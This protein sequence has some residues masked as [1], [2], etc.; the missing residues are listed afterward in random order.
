VA[1]PDFVVVG[2]VVLDVAPQGW[3]LG[4]TATFAA[5]QAQR[6]GLRAGIVTRVGSEVAL[7]TELPGIALAGGPSSD[8]TRF[9]NLYEGGRRRQRVLA[10]ADVVSEADVPQAWRDAPT[11]L[12][13]PVC[14]EAPP[15]LAN[16]FGS[17]IVGVSAQGWLRKVDRR[18]RVLRQAWQGEPFWSG[19][20]VLFVSDEDL[21]RRWEQLSR[22]EADVPIVA[23]TRAHRGAQVHHTGHWQ[24][25]DAFPAR[26]TDPT[27]AGDVFAAAFLVRYYETN[28]VAQASRFASAASA[29]SVQGQGIDCI[30]TREEIEAKMAAHPEIALQ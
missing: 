13:G 20:R 2:H 28:D 12:L 5:V 29:C 23:L 16:A 26:H 21:G 10:Q 9:E 11:V 19:C 25:I 30:A 1:T 4:G 27:G 24:H 8:T 18:H 22:W 17:G 7:E 3:R 6:L 14:G 15:S